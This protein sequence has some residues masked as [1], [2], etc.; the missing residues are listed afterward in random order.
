MAWT[1][2]DGLQVRLASD[3]KQA[4]LR[5]NRPGSL[6]SFGALKEIEIDVDLKLLPAGVVNFTADLNNDGT[7]DG[8]YNGDVSLPA[9]SSIISAY[10]VSGE[11]A[12][13]GTSLAVGLYQV[14]GTAISATG[15]LT[16]AAGV[17]ANMAVG[18]RING[19]GALVAT[20]AGTNGVGAT[21]AYIGMTATG[22]FTAGKGRL[23]IQ[24]IDAQPNPTDL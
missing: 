3:W 11:T 14:N 15:I 18:K 4:A 9:N 8:F 16:A 17:T 6:N 21:R 1:N 20:A 13:G 12:V 19:D 22:T 5:K 24:Y 10:Y 7:R 23:V 2:T